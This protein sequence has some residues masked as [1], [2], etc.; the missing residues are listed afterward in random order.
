MAMDRDLVIPGRGR[1]P[2]TRNPEIDTVRVS[3]F[4]VRPCGR[5]GM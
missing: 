5:P 2:R 3:G 1:R 4:R